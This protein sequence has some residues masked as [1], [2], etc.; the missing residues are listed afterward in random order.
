MNEGKVKPGCLTFL[1]LCS[2]S[3]SAAPGGGSLQQLAEMVLEDGR[4]ELFPFAPQHAAGL[5][6]A[7]EA[8]KLSPAH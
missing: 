3:L 1:C 8:H 5:L 6:S 2:S 7:V 4:V